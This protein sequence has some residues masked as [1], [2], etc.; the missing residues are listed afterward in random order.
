MEEQF[1]NTN[2]PELLPTLTSMRDV[3]SRQAGV[4]TPR[5]QG[6]PVCVSSGPTSA[7]VKRMAASYAR[8][9][10]LLNLAEKELAA[11]NLATV[12]GLSQVAARYAFPGHAGILGSRRLERLL[13]EAGKRLPSKSVGVVHGRPGNPRRVLHVLSY[14]RPVGGDTRFVWRWIQEDPDNQHS[15]AITSQADVEDLYDIPELLRTSAEATGGFLRILQ[16]STSDPLEQAHELRALCQQVDLVVLHPF[17]Y[18]VVPVLALASGCEGVT[19]LFVNHSDHTFWIGA[20]VAHS[21]V[22]LRQ[23][24][25]EF[26]RERRYLKA[27]DAPVLPIPLSHSAPSMS[28]GEA[29]RQLGYGPD[30]VILLTIA[31]PF[32]YRSPDAIGFLD[33]VTPVLAEL[34]QARLIA[35]GPEP[36]DSWQAA[37]A[38]TGGRIVPMGT[39]WNTELLYAAADIYL[40]SVPFS[41]ITS[42]VEAGSYGH[43]LLGYGTLDA[44]LSLLGPGAPGIDHTMI[45]AQDPAEYRAQL[46]RL[47]TDA[48]YRRKCGQRVKDAVLSFHTGPNWGNQV[49]R[50]YAHAD[51]SLHRDCL[52]EQS[53]GFRV[54]PLSLALDRLY[55]PWS[56]RSLVAKYIGRLPYRS[57]V[58]TTLR[59]HSFG[60]D[61]CYVNLLPPPLDP[62]VQSGGRWVKR[63]LRRLNRYR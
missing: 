12:V 46:A 5:R 24:S 10:D 22:H 21:V 7:D 52:L 17:P 14:G 33:L 60:L 54:S 31:S 30:T 36:N 8:F 47:I 32:K 63:V 51:R 57:R 23:Q 20:S 3:P 50:L 13:L 37:Q 6:A 9:C 62:I 2:L 27:D 43:P 34:P 35:V 19:T 15:V 61:L 29:R 49:R 44:E 39:R 42:L 58:T 11:G 38:R 55:P 16:A 4:G 25:S 1:C 40:D 56:V 45:V 53:D 26:L 48:E 18:D 28:P 59:L 41:S